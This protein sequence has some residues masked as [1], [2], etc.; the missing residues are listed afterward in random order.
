MKYT[1]EQLR[2]IAKEADRNDLLPWAYTDKCHIC[3][4]VK[5]FVDWLE[6]NSQDG[7]CQE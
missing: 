2:T 3:G 4:G 6:R 7:V 5:A 1:I